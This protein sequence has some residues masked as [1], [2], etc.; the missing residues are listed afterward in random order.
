[1]ISIILI[2]ATFISQALDA[3]DRAGLVYDAITLPPYGL[4]DYSV[5]FNFLNYLENEMHY[6]P[7]LSIRTNLFTIRDL[8]NDNSKWDVSHCILILK[9][10]AI[11]DSKETLTMLVI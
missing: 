11:C 3:Q 2:P 1:M 4:M 5:A 10:Y 9:H 6:V 7:W 8:L